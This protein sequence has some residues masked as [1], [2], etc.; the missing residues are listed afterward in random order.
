MDRSTARLFALA[1]S[2]TLL[3][4]CAAVIPALQSGAAAIAAHASAAPLVA[5]AGAA[6]VGLG[7]GVVASDDIK[8]L[9]KEVRDTSYGTPSP[10]T[11]G[12][13]FQENQKTTVALVE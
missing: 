11:L 2:V 6:G 8:R 4:G 1:A 12:A 9:A 3:A 10:G 13:Y 7:V 5:A